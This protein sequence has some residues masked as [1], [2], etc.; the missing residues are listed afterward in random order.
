MG[1][2]LVLVVL[3]RWKQLRFTVRDALWLTLVVAIGFGWFV[4]RNELSNRLQEA[5][6]AQAQIEQLRLD[7]AVRAALEK[8]E[9]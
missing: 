4:E 6:E 9:R 5:Q 2:C 3:R 8:A 1:V 7:P